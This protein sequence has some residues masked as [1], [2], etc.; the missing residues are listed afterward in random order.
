ML[1]KQIKNIYILKERMN[2][3]L[4]CVSV[5]SMNFYMSVFDEYSVT[6][7]VCI[8]CMVYASVYI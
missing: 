1:Q 6:A 7:S 5:Y 3:S 4:E 2:G 8:N